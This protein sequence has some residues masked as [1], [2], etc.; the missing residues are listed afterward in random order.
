MRYFIIALTLLFLSCGTPPKDIK[1][2]NV[3]DFIVVHTPQPF[4]KITG[5]LVIKGEARGTFFFEGDFPVEV[6]LANGELIQH[7]AMADD[8]WMTEEF[9]PFTSTID[10]SGLEPQDI[11]IKLHRNNPSDNREN[12]MVMEL[13]VTID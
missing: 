12:D 3:S 2:K 8:E 11:T 13:P 4:E 7:Y 9:V 5:T 6:V 10:I 1:L